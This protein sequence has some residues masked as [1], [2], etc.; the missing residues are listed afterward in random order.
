MDTPVWDQIQREICEHGRLASKSCYE[1]CETCNRDEHRCHFCGDDLRHDGR[2]W[3]GDRNPCYLPLVKPRK[4]GPTPIYDQLVRERWG[5]AMERM[6]KSFE[7]L[8]EAFKKLGLVAGEV[9]ASGGSSRQEVSAGPPSGHSLPDTS[10]PEGLD[11]WTMR[12]KVEP[13]PGQPGKMRLAEDLRELYRRVE[14][15][16]LGR[17]QD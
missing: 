12:V 6:K 7:P 4:A 11:W 16:G 10:R 13:V 9:V 1:C 17:G 15:Q 8:V 2:L 5:T 14:E 3:N